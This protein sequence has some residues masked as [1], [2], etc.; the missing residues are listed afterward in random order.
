MQEV[1]DGEP[2]SK[3]IQVKFWDG[4]EADLDINDTASRS[5]SVKGV[6][7]E[8]PLRFLE[9]Y[10]NSPAFTRNARSLAPDSA[11]GSAA[12]LTTYEEAKARFFP[13]INGQKVDIGPAIALPPF[14]WRDA[15]TG[16][17][18]ASFTYN[19]NAFYRIFMNLSAEGKIS[20]R[21]VNNLVDRGCMLLSQIYKAGGHYVIQ[22]INNNF[23]MYLISRVV[24]EIVGREIY[25][26]EE[27]E[28]NLT[29]QSIEATLRLTPEMLSYSVIEKMGFALGMG[30]AFAERQIRQ[31]ESA[32]N[33]HEAAQHSAF[34]Y[35]SVPSIAID[36]R[37]RL[38][39]KIEATITQAGHFTL[40]AILDDAAE[41]V[42]DLLWMQDVMRQFPGF[43]VNLLVNTAQ[44]SINF[45]LH[46][47]D[48]VLKHPTFCL[49]AQDLDKQ[50]QVTNIYCPFISFQTNYL[51]AEAWSVINPSDAV[52]VKGANFFETCQIPE[53]DS[54]HAFVV[55][56]P[57]SRGY[58]GLK[59]YDAVFVHL[60]RGRPG[61]VHH[62]NPSEIVNLMKLV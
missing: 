12:S 43:R 31:R 61:F 52:Y 32:R 30:V 4:R 3:I 24:E 9:I 46:L 8:N 54:F 59:D 14:C 22:H 7:F 48:A 42:I 11:A 5:L 17:L 19:T 60:P 33:I 58:T 34:R 23:N 57:V 29:R 62:E 38:L 25:S 56:G 45:S 16:K 15:D 27:Q 39:E 51:P 50:F 2:R 18:A 49:L 13:V 41:T 53:K 37:A 6:A 47:L 35:Y 20:P 26:C 44:T 28:L 10:A 1:N 55:Y 21:Q 40:A 36:H